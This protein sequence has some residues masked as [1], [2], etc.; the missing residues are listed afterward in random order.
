MRYGRDMPRLLLATLGVVTVVAT[1]SCDTSK[2][3]NRKEW[4]CLESER[5]NFKDPDSVKF[6]ANLGTRGEG[7]DPE[8]NFWVRYM[9]KNGFGAYEQRNMKCWVFVG[10]W[11]RD[12]AGEALAV[13]NYR[14]THLDVKEPGRAA[15]EAVFSGTG[16]LEPFDGATRK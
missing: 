4:E 16:D 14:A 1:T 13:A 9:A 3:T 2:L 10:G 12:A 5:F 15:I 7:Y 8:R 6:V 11:K